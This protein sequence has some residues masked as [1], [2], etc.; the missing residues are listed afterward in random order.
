MWT[1]QPTRVVRGQTLTA[2]YSGAGWSAGFQG[3]RWRPH[4]RM[5][6]AQATVCARSGS[7]VLLALHSG[8]GL[9]QGADTVGSGGPA[10][11]AP[12]GAPC[13]GRRRDWRRMTE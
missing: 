2:R 4:R 9:G 6:Q 1:D 10:V 8:G 12:L 11:V 5:G 3:A 13:L 7:G